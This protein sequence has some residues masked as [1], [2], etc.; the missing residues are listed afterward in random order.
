MRIVVITVVTAFAVAT[1]PVVIL[2][3]TR[4]GGVEPTRSAG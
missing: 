3:L 1:I 4:D 2:I